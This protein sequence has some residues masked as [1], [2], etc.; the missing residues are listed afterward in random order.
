[1][2]S[3]QTLQRVFLAGI[4]LALAW[5]TWKFV[6]RSRETGYLGARAAAALAAPLLDAVTE[7]SG[8]LHLF[9]SP[10]EEGGKTVAWLVL[11]LDANDRERASVRVNSH[12]G[13]IEGVDGTDRWVIAEAM[14]P[15]SELEAT[16]T[17]RRWLEE[18]SLAD[19]GANW[20]VSRTKLADGDEWWVWWEADDRAAVISV[21]ASSSS[22]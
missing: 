8:G 14:D 7:G 20:R 13:L 2:L 1:M 6:G 19:Q 5:M 9:T 12:T 15:M 16:D 11:A 18:C 21:Q 22:R 17:A 4:L 10:L 3:R